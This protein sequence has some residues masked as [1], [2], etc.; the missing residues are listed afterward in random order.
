MAEKEKNRLRTAMRIVLAISL[1]PWVFM[2]CVAVYSFFAG[3]TTGL[4]Q[5]AAQIY[6]T[7]AFFY[8]CDIYLFVFAPVYVI[9]AITAL[10][11]FIILIVI[12]KKETSANEKCPKVIMTCGRICSGKSTYAQKLRKEYKAV[13]LSV[14]EITLALFGNEAGE[15]L[16]E[17]VERSEKYLFEKSVE[18]IQTGISVVL[19]WGLWTKR[20]RTEARE[21]YNNHGIP[22][23][24]H[25]L[26]IPDDEWARRIGKRNADISAGRTDAYFVD[27]GLAEKVNTLFEKPE[28]NEIDVRVNA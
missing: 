18:I 27:D 4:F 23:E 9:T 8:T 22:C 10:V 5:A 15:K 21:F 25:Y 14:D 19:D 12:R 6:G 26:D 11:G 24:I 1:I 16:D 13:I 3:T 7:E 20:E 17:Y 28:D 2:L